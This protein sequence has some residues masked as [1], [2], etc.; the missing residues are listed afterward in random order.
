MTQTSFVEI[1]DLHKDF[2][3]VQ[4]LKGINISL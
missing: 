2:S 4:V 1:R 3:G